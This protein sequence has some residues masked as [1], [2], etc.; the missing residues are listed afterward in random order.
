MSAPHLD[1]AAGNPVRGTASGGGLL[2]FAGDTGFQAEVKRRVAEY[3]ARTG[4]SPARQ[5]AHVREDRG[6][7]ALVRRLVRVAGLRGDHLVAGAAAVG[8]AGVRDGGYR[9]RR[10]ARRQP[11][12]L[13]EPPR[14]QP[15]DGD[16]ARLRGRELVPLALAAQHLSSHLHEP[17]RRRRRHQL[18]PVRPALPGAA[19]LPHAPLPAVLPVGALR[20]PGAEVALHRRLQ[21]RRAGP[22]SPATGSRGPAACVSSRPSAESCCSSAGRSRSRCCSIAGGSC[23]S[24]TR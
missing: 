10:P 7:R 23:C 13:L 5:P 18:P 3:F 24:S 1:L 19:A 14:R 9:L 2:K 11:R 20:V 16:V 21:E 6:D 8:L 4:L 12:R 17:R 15:P 22:G